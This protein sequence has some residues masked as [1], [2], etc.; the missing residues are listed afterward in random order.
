MSIYLCMYRRLVKCVFMVVVARF[1]VARFLVNVS[2][3]LKA[4]MRVNIDS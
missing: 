4:S 1:L 2:G 3:C